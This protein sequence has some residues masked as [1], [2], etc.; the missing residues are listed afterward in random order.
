MAALG[1]ELRFHAVLP[2]GE[3]VNLD[4]NPEIMTETELDEIEATVRAS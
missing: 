1:G 2:N 4:E 3:D